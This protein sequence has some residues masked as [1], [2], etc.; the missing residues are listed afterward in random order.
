MFESPSRLLL[1]LVS[2]VLFGFLLQKGRVAKFRV[3]L[4]QFLLTDWT[5]VKIML[6]AVA[7]GAVGVWA[8]IPMGW[9]ELH[10]KPT[11]P[12]GIILGGILF[13]IG[14]AVF[15]TYGGYMA[16]DPRLPVSGGIEWARNWRGH[17]QNCGKH[18]P[19]P[20]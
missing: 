1:G 7:V 11:L 12:G 13:G 16:Q 10:V 18:R 19:T 3:I 14:M 4:G 17:S 20:M 8:M 9:A 2:G 6:T 5:V 15:I